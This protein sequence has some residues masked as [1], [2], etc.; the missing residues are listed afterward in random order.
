MLLPG[1][2]TTVPSHAQAWQDWWAGATV[3]GYVGHLNGEQLSG[4]SILQ[5]DVLQG[6]LSCIYAKLGGHL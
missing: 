6:D 4:S 1:K 2:R 3:A 5:L